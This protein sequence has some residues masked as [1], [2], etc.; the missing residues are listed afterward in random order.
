M[1]GMVPAHT[2]GT[3]V[4]L[5]ENT[6]RLLLSQLEANRRELEKT[7]NQLREAAS[8][9]GST[10]EREAELR[11]LAKAIA[12]NVL[13]TESVK[14]SSKRTLANTGKLTAEELQKRLDAEKLRRIELELEVRENK[15]DLS[16]VKQ[17]LRE[18]QNRL[19]ERSEE[20]KKEGFIEESFEKLV[21][22]A[23]EFYVRFMQGRIP[24][25]KDFERITTFHFAEC[26]VHREGL[27]C[28]LRQRMG[29]GKFGEFKNLK[30]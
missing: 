9:Y 13:K 27:L 8:R 16:L 26:E 15:G 18:S 11:K 7:R 22:G 6:T 28:S 24:E 3:G 2:G 19:K 20:I 30:K 14:S 21:A 23:S 5:D 29:L 25:E 4:G 12:E 17:I 1:T 10:P